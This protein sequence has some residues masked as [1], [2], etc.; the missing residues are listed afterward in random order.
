MRKEQGGPSPGTR[1]PA[2]LLWARPP[3]AAGLVTQMSTNAGDRARHGAQ[4]SVP[5]GRHPAT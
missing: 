3:P 2:G 5:R 4:R 1:H